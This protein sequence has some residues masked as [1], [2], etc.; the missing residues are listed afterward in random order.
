MTAATISEGAAVWK[1]QPSSPSSL[2]EENG[3]PETTWAGRLRKGEREAHR[4]QQR[5]PLCVQCEARV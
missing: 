5:L 3:H 4:L 2:A 1:N